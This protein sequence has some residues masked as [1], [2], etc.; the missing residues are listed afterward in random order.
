M[1]RIPPIFNVFIND[2]LASDGMKGVNVPGL[3]ERIEGLMLHAND[4]A[5]LADSPVELQTSL[6][7]TSEWAERWGMKF[8]HKEVHCNDILAS[9]GMKGVN[10]PGL[11]E[12]IEGLI[13]AND[14]ALLADSPVELQTSLNKTS[15]WADR[16][17]MKFSIK[18]CVVMDFFGDMKELKKLTFRLGG[19]TVPIGDNYRY[20]GIFGEKHHQ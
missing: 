15:E 20:L 9:D 14:L 18:N 5:L 4:L 6:N 1:P 13:F 16:W 10:I 3:L 11:V 8:G 19:E 17:G 7:R 12:H 2:I